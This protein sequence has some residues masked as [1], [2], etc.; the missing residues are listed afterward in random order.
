MSSDKHT[1]PIPIASSRRRASS[2][3]ASDSSPDSASA[4]DSSSSYSPTSPLSPSLPAHKSLPRIAPVSPSS[5]PILSYFLSTSPT[6][7][8]AATFPFRRGFNSAVFDGTSPSFS[9]LITFGAHFDLAEE[10]ESANTPANSPVSA[11][12]NSTGANKNPHGRR[13]SMASWPLTTSTSIPSTNATTATTKATTNAAAPIPETQSDRASGLLRRLSLGGALTASRPAPPKPPTPPSPL[14][15]SL[16]ERTTSATV[17]DNAPRVVRKTRRANTLAPGS[18]RPPRAPSP[19][20][21]R[22]LKGHFDGF[23]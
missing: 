13:A 8:P 2:I 20:G 5:S 22:I 17:P 16:L 21:E 18:Q 3:S 7:S 19:M 1:E 23:N 4:S 11:N 6:K 12:P 15:G 10:D 9:A 14:S